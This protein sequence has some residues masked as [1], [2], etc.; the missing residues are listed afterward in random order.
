M[1][2]QLLVQGF[3]V[4]IVTNNVDAMVTFYQD[5][6]GLEF[7][8]ELAFA[9]GRM[10]RFALGQSVLKLV[11]FDAPPAQSVPPAGGQAATGFRYVTL[12]AGNLREIFAK[13]EASEHKVGE[14]IS[15]FQ[16]GL[17]FF[18]VIDPDG[19]WIELAGSI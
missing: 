14:P 2:V 10:K 5:F 3:E 11:T 12:V 15:E 8:G 13:V 19:N 1:T 6:L 17:G 7:Q 18:F 9:H 4:G 16:P